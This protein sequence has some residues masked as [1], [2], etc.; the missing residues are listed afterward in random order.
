F[1]KILSNEGLGAFHYKSYGTFLVFKKPYN[2]QSGFTH[3]RNYRAFLVGHI[4]RT[5]KTSPSIKRG[6][7]SCLN[8]YLERHVLKVS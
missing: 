4:R 5:I 1:H 2:L 6:L 7:G 8:Y 3:Y